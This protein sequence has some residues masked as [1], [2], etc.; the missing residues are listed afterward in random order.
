MNYTSTDS[1]VLIQ[2]DNRE[3]MRITKD[4]IWVNPEMSVNDAAKKVLEALE[5]NIKYLC[6]RERKNL[7]ICFC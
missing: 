4:G 5:T 1:M 3:V 7:S 2:A 6:E